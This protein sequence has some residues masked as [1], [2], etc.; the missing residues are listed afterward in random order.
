[1]SPMSCSILWQNLKFTVLPTLRSGPC[2]QTL[3]DR[4]TED[5][6]PLLHHSPLLA[7]P[8]E[9]I[10][11][12]TWCLPSSLPRSPCSSQPSAGTH[13]PGQVLPL[14]L[15]LQGW[16]CILF[17]SATH[18]ANCVLSL[19]YQLLLKL[20]QS[21]TLP[22]PQGSSVSCPRLWDSKDCMN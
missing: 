2:P 21:L 7:W 1:M 3:A 9:V 22:V 18:R 14:H 5:P 8:Q 4:H 13:S 17:L 15:G 16:K 12:F 20:E 10:S 11:H 19:R 6:F